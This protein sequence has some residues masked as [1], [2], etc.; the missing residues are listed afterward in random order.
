MR[1]PFADLEQLLLTSAIAWRGGKPRPVPPRSF[2][3]EVLGMSRRQVLR[4]RE[5]GLTVVQ[6]DELAI[7]AGLQAAEVWG[8]AWWTT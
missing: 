4:L 5:R 3:A 8:E 7:T 1:F 6:A 2:V